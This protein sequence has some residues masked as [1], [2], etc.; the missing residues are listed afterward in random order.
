MSALGAIQSAMVAL[1]PAQLAEVPIKAPVTN[2]TG[3]TSVGDNEA[4]V[5]V[6]GAMDKTM[7]DRVIK[8]GDRV[9]ASFLTVAVV[10]GVIGGSAFMVLGS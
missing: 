7:A 1:P 10:G 4:G 9:A 3:G 2:S 8:T 6:N 5:K